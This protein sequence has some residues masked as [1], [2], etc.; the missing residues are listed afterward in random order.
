MATEYMVRL[1]RC[2][3]QATHV[4][5]SKVAGSRRNNQAHQVL[6]LVLDMVLF[7]QLIVV[8]MVVEV[9]VQYTASALVA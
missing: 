3:D 9:V 7:D 1:A 8:D 2:V 4:D 5:A 6:D